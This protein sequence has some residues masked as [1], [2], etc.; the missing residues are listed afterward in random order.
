MALQISGTWNNQTSNGDLADWYPEGPAPGGNDA[1]NDYSNPGVINTVSSNDITLMEAL[2]WTTQVNGIV[3]T[4]NTSEALQGGPAITLL[5]TAP[6]ITDSGQTTL[7]SATG[8]NYQWQRRYGGG[9]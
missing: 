5:A 8:E 2:G 9:R 7:T 4:A 3:V 1:F 6:V